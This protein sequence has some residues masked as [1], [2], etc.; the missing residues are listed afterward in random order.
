VSPANIRKIVRGETWK[1]LLF[2]EF[3]EYQ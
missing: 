1:H 2:G 3:N